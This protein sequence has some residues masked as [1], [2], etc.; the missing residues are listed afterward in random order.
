MAITWKEMVNGVTLTGSAVAYYTTPALNAATIQA[1]T[2]YNPTG[3][4][5]VVNFYKVPAARAAD[6]T[7]LICTRSIPAG[8]TITL[9]ETLN[10]KL[11]AATQ[12]F[13][14]GAGLTLVV[15]GVEYVSE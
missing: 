9:N 15:S 13:A 2:A 12:I 14:S 10:H 6:A 11:Q 5:L 3:G 1:A 8:S 4:A 7:T